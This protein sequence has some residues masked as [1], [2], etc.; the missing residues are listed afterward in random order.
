MPTLPNLGLATPTLGGDSGEWDDKINA[1]FSLLD[2]HD[3]TAGKGVLVPVAG[4]N[5]NADFVM[6]GWGLTGV[7]RVDFNAVAALAAGANVLF[8]SSAD[9]ELYWRTTGGT[10]VKLTNGA[11]INTTLVGGIVGDYSTVGAEVSYSDAD[12]IYTFKDENDK[13]ARIAAGTVRIFEHDT[14]ES[15]Y[16]EF[17]APAALAVS[18]TVTWPTAVPGAAAL[19]QISAAGVVSFSNTTTETLT[20][21]AYLYTTATTTIIPS[22]MWAATGTHALVT[23]GYWAWGA[24]A[25]D[26]L[27]VPVP[28]VVG[29]TLTDFSIYMRKDSDNT[30]TVTATLVK[31]ASDTGFST[32]IATASSAANA[33]GPITLSPAGFAEAITSVT[34]HYYEVKITCDDATPSGV[35]QFFMATA[36]RTRLA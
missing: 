24:T 28:V 30:N 12:Q 22:S 23:G 13:W 6:G 3:H 20:A 31:R 5:I 35:D 21:G 9:G 36:T 7:G 29:E 17:A 8:T 19:M 18:Y 4:L 11:S 2:A 10:N 27:V 16:V 32:T 14:T 1:C 25:S 26:Q 33:P 15:V 34:S